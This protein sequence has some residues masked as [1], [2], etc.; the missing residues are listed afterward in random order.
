M[1]K[2]L[3]LAAVGLALCS[4]FVSCASTGG[5]EKAPASIH[6]REYVF[7]MI[8]AGESINVPKNQY[9]PNYQYYGHLW[10]LAKKDKPQAGDTVTFHIR[11]VSDIDIPALQ[12]DVVDSSAAASYWTVLSSADN[13]A[14]IVAENIVAGE[15]FE[16]ELTYVLEKSSIAAF[17]FVIFYDEA[18]GKAANIKFE[19]VCESTDTNNE[20]PSAP[21]VKDVTVEVGKVAAFFEVAT[22]HPWVDGGFDQSVISNYQG[23]VD[24]MTVYT[25][26]TLPKAGDTITAHW[27]A[28]SDVDIKA[29]HMRVFDNSP[30]A[31]WWTELDANG[32][33]GAIFVEDIKAGEPFEG[34]LTMTYVKDAIGGAALVVWYDIG[35]AEPN[36]PATII[37]VR[38]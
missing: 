19:R 15:P 27:K 9:G 37:M 31:N 24:L 1:K 36:G 14:Q 13:Q 29:L 6:P 12:A 33:D 17:D 35:D 7:D 22:N 5:K 20:V 32:G 11:G 34:E 4:L 25:P 18:V 21:H 10:S 2:L 38:D 30:A 3:S 16:G 23:I 8:D 26:D 28:K